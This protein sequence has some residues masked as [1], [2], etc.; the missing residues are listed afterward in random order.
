MAANRVVTEAPAALRPARKQ[1]SPTSRGGKTPP[2]GQGSPSSR[3]CSASERQVAERS[4]YPPV[5]PDRDC[6]CEEVK[7]DSR[8]VAPSGEGRGTF[9]ASPTPGLL[10]KWE[11]SHAGKVTV[12]KSPK[13]R[14]RDREQVEE[15]LAR[16]EQIYPDVIGGLSAKLL[17]NPDCTPHL[18]VGYL[19]GIAF[20]A[21]DNLSVELRGAPD[22]LSAE[23]PDPE[24]LRIAAVQIAQV[25]DQIAE[26]NSDPYM[27]PNRVLEG[28]LQPGRWQH[29]ASLFTQ[30]PAGLR[31][32]SDH[33]RFQAFRYGEIRKTKPHTQKLFV[34]KPASLT[35]GSSR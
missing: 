19:W 1:S 29:F 22:D 20:H 4:L 17:K 2:S 9:P 23:L 11:D 3:E 7:P 33:L 30:L 25:A 31:A 28:L 27:N 21:N 10:M 6:T 35:W 26:L 12:K 24:K 5:V 16:L 34:M 18:T 32:Y 14:A 15:F 8:W 13:A